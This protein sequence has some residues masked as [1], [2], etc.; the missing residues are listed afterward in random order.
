M[1][2][3]PITIAVEG[4]TDVPVARRLIAYVGGEVGPIHVT[5]GKARL[6]GQLAGYDRAAAFAPWFVLRDLNGDAPCAGVL[7]QRLL[8]ASAAGMCLRIPV[9]SVEAWLLAD[10]E[11]V[12]AYF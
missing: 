7:K 11:R 8:P 1:T 3:S 4:Q 2:R 5:R 9:R 6:D 10:R 12:A